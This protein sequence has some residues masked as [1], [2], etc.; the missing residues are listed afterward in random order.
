MDK[1]DGVLSGRFRMEMF[2]D[3]VVLQAGDLLVVPRGTVHSAEVVGNE[4]VMSLDAVK[5][6]V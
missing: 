2:G 5:L 6:S 4:V 1:I 3:S